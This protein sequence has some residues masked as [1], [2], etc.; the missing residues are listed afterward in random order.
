MLNIELFK[1]GLCQILFF[2][3]IF[4]LCQILHFQDLDYVHIPR[5]SQFVIKVVLSIMGCHLISLLFACLLSSRLIH[6]PSLPRGSPLEV[7]GPLAYSGNK[8]SGG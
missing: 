4:A 6:A 3:L 8:F 7:S 2:F 1:I 5:L